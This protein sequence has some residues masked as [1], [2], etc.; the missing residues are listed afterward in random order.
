LLIS[1]IWKERK[2]R[3]IEKVDTKYREWLTYELMKAKEEMIIRQEK[4]ED[5]KSKLKPQTFLNGTSRFLQ[6]LL[7]RK[8]GQGNSAVNQNS[9]GEKRNHKGDKN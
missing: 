7:F 1:K 9:Y 8:I 2:T 5:H 6:H 4:V 3:N